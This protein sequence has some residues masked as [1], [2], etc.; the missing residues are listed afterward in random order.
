MPRYEVTRSSFNPGAAQGP[1]VYVVHD[2]QRSF[3]RQDPPHTVAARK[4]GLCQFRKGAGK[5]VVYLELQLQKHKDDAAV[6]PPPVYY[7]VVRRGAANHKIVAELTTKEVFLDALASATPEEVVLDDVASEEVV[8]DDVA[9][10]EVVL[11]A[12]ASEEV[13]LDA[14]ASEEV[15]IE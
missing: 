9:S 3:K 2:D 14:V 5:A 8:L 7:Y 1:N 13:V 15:V 10:E 6:P 4:A 12:V 11:D